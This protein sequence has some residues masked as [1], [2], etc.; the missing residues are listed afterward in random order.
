MPRC[1]IS[2]S[3]ENDPHK[4]WVRTLAQRLRKDGVDVVLDQWDLVPG[5]QLPEF[6][7]GAIR[8]ADFVLIV[9]TPAY[10]QKSEE[11]KGGVG[12]EGDIITGE[13]F[14]ERNHRK[15]IPI[16]RS[17][18]ATPSW[19]KGKYYIDL[20]GDPYS[21]QHYDDLLTTLH[22]TRP[23]APPLGS[24]PS[25]KEIRPVA[26]SHEPTAQPPQ[27]FEPIRITGVIADEVSMPRNDGSRGSALYRVP[28][29]LSRRPPSDW[30]QLFV[31]NWNRPPRWTTMHR[32]GIASVVGDKV[33][34]DGTTIDEVER[35]HRDTLLLALDETNRI[36]VEH[37]TRERRLAAGAEEQRRQHEQ[38]IRDA[39]NRLKFE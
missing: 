34:L 23:K 7:E 18:N 20:S 24:A 30:A 19:M 8:D 1:F 10:K 35:Y 2:Y 28:F 15:F 3:W 5:D 26:Q 32:P 14:T 4:E 38:Q 29:R 21:E 6:M 31:H 16:M 11:R 17:G 13:V 37:E 22:G 39:A 27:G 33:I 36:W 12:Y 9:C 25:K